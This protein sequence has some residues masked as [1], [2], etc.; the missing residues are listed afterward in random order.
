[1]QKR[2][3]VGIDVGGTKI[4]AGLV[5]PAGKIL[6][7]AKTATPP[8]ST[9]AQVI[10]CVDLLLKEMFASSGMQLKNLSGIGIGIPGIM[11]AQGKV[12]RTPNM[13]LTGAPL[14]KLLAAK[15]KVKIALGNDA[16]LG[17]LG[18]KWL[19]AAREAKN[20]VGIFAGTGIGAGVIIDN[21]LFTG[22]HGAGAELGHMIIRDQ[23]PKCGCGNQG[24]LESLTGRWAME[25]DIKKSL[26]AGKT[27]RVKKLS[28]RKNQPIKSGILR[29][30]IA[31]KDPLVLK[32][33]AEASRQL[34]IACISVRHI[35]DP[36]MIVLGGG[37]IEACGHFILPIVNKTFQKNKFFSGIGRCDIVASKLGDDAIILGAVYLV[38]QS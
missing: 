6:A 33:M 9:A 4:A 23:G 31:K 14:A 5:T 18:E 10:R 17:A 30:A 38:R 2:L 29:E 13:R 28:H 12:I 35:F 25:R 27:T 1:M 26:A 21:R 36:E 8:R 16:N 37:V 20:I 15:F 7:R 24:C 11:D 19:G 32:I 3:F 34:G 22:S